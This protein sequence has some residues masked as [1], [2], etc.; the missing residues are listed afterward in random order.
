MASFLKCHSMVFITLLV[1]RSISD[2][3]WTGANGFA[4]GGVAAVEVAGATLLAGLRLWRSSTA[5]FLP[6][7]R[8]AAYG[9]GGFRK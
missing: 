7:L 8:A 2:A 1:A 9:K 6:E 3:D 5:P 4:A